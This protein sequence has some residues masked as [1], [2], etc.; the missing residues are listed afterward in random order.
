MVP[1]VEQHAAAASSWWPRSLSPWPCSRPP[2]QT[3]STSRFS[4]CR[5][6]SRHPLRTRLHLGD[7]R[8]RYRRRQRSRRPLPSRAV[9]RSPRS[10]H[11]LRNHQRVRRH[12]RRQ[13]PRAAARRSR[14]QVRV[15]RRRRVA[16]VVARRQLQRRVQRPPPQP[17]RPQPRPRRSG[18]FGRRAYPTSN[19]IPTDTS[20]TSSGITREQIILWSSVGGG[21]LAIV[22]GIVLAAYC[23][24]RQ[25]SRDVSAKGHLLYMESAA[26]GPTTAIVTRVPLRDLA[27]A[28]T[29]PPSGAPTPP[30][31]QCSEPM[32][33]PPAT[34]ALLRRDSAPAVD[35]LLPQEMLSPTPADLGGP[36]VYISP[37]AAEPVMEP[38]Y[39][40]RG[41][42]ARASG[43]A[44]GH[45]E[46]ECGDEGRRG[47]GTVRIAA[48]AGKRARGFGG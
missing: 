15:R 7:R 28:V 5:S 30:P 36:V 35:S 8:R 3:R 10:H 14:H 38:Y 19:T 46:C 23:L 20:G 45:D 40:G 26:T 48:A 27:D 44:T 21:A 24:A 37:R 6:R 31:P 1:P 47:A 18:S 25:R 41:A 17:A 33:P 32:S 9:R 16:A 2:Q 11:R 29:T 39:M 12:R 4:T 22:L 42:R 34:A 43:G 13:H